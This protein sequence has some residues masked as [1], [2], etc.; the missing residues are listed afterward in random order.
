MGGHAGESLQCMSKCTTQD[1]GECD[2]AIV[3]A[4][5]FPQVAISVLIPAE[6]AFRCYTRVLYV[7][8]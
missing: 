6:L 5:H 8:W 7:C 3:V 1:A 2:T 4:Q